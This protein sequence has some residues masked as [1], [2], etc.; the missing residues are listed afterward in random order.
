MTDQLLPNSAYL[1]LCNWNP[2]DGFLQTLESD[3]GTNIRWNER[4]GHND[5]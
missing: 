2:T 1:K 5:L 3:S 4:E